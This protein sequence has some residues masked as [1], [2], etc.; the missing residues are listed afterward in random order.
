MGDAV[1][2]RYEGL[3]EHGRRDLVTSTEG[4]VGGCGEFVKVVKEAFYSAEVVDGWET[5]SWNRVE[6]GG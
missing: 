1:L 2:G 3:L 4:E 5:F 6:D